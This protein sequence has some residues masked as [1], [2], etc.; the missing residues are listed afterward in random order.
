MSDPA[1][2][3]NGV[4]TP[5]LRFSMFSPASMFSPLAVCILFYLPTPSLSSLAILVMSHFKWTFFAA[6]PDP[7][8]PSFNL[9]LQ[10]DTSLSSPD[11]LDSSLDITS[12]FLPVIRREVA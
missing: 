12:W 2:K 7:L 10:F 6:S 5:F 9:G 11:L 8:F 4:D 3:T 1:L